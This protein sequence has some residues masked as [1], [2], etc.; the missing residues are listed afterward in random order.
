MNHPLAG[1]FADLPLIAILRGVTPAEAPAIGI[2]IVEAGFRIVEVPLNSPEPLASIRGLVAA[3]GERA[4]IGAGTVLAAAEVEAVAACGVRL[5]V[6]PNTD[7]AV[8][9][10]AKAAGLATAPG[11]ATPTEAFAAIAAGADLLKLFPAEILGPAAVKAWRAVLPHDTPLVPVG[12]VTPENVPAWRA[13]GAAGL[14]LG[15][16]IYAPGMPVPEVARRA[17]AF[18]AAWRAAGTA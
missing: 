5:V 13:A 18:V 11:V 12:G 3:I 7:S 14:G 9:R 17:R 1:H 6:S 10:T 4:T 15:S 2:A 16:A 8:I